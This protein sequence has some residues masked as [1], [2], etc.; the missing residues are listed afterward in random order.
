MAKTKE[1]KQQE[2]YIRDMQKKPDYYFSFAGYYIF[3]TWYR[4]N[5]LT[6][7]QAGMLIIMSYYTRMLSSDFKLWYLHYSCHERALSDLVHY[8]YITKVIL[9][10]KGGR[11][12]G[13]ACYTLTPMGVAFAKDYEKFYDIKY[14]ELMK[15]REAKKYKFDMDEYFRLFRKPKNV[16]RAEIG[17][18]LY[19]PGIAK[20]DMV[21][22]H[23]PIHSKHTKLH[24]TR[25]KVDWM[26]ELKRFRIEMK[27]KLK[28]GET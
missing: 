8:G 9:T 5:N 12:T 2:I 14:A 20:E 3:E 6:K 28:N 4:V 11:G 23:L 17:G 18:E 7:I 25:D 26:D 19:T 1:E 15:K 22:V 10:A 27:N 13:T 16:R 21:P 24:V